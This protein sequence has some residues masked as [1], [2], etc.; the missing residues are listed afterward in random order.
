M[1]FL[2]QGPNGLDGVA[3]ETLEASC[4]GDPLPSPTRPG[5]GGARAHPY[6]TPPWLKMLL[7]S[8]WDY[9][10]LSPRVTCVSSSKPLTSLGIG[11]PT[12]GSWRSNSLQPQLRQGSQND[13]AG[14]R[15]TVP[16]HVAHGP[17]LTPL[18][19]L[20]VPWGPLMA[21]GHHSWVSLLQGEEVAATTKAVLQVPRSSM[22]STLGDN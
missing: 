11:L 13:G 5:V 1:A 9:S 16:T 4:P 17:C 18:S 12:G 6:R 7:Q 10:P 22:P 8:V 20:S 2:S 19:R 14:G 3:L 21:D 15:G